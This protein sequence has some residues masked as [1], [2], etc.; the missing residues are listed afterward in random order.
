M[1]QIQAK[2]MISKSARL[3]SI[4]AHT[5]LSLVILSATILAEAQRGESNPPRGAQN[6]ISPVR[7]IEQPPNR[8]EN[9]PR[10]EASSQSQIFRSINGSNNN[11]LDPDIGAAN[12]TLFRLLPS[13]YGDGLSTLAGSNRL[14]AREISNALSAQTESVPNPM[15]ATDFLWQWGQ[16]LDHDIDLTDGADPAEPSPI[17]VPLGDSF[18]DPSG[19][20]DV[21][22]SFNRSIYAAELTGPREQL[23]EITGWIDA[24]NV[25][26]SD[27]ERANALRTLAGDGKLK[28]SAGNL[29]PFN[30]QGFPNAGGDSANLFLAGDVRANEQTGL[31]AMHTLFVREH[32]RLAELVATNNQNWDGEQIYQKTRQLVGAEMQVITYQEFLPTLLG[33]RALGRYQGYRENINASI[34]NSFST[35]AYRFGHSALSPTLL[36][37]DANGQESIHGHLALR[38]AFFSS[39]NITEQGGIEPL[40]RGLASQT[41]QA[42]DL[43]VIDDVRNFLFGAPGAGGFDLAALNIQRG[44]DHGLPSYN[45]FRA[46][47]GLAPHTEFADISSNPETVDQL[48]SVYDSVDAIDL[49]VG[50][51]AEEAISGSHLGALFHAIV[52]DQFEALR[53]GD[54]YWYTLTLNET[55]RQMVESLSLAD[56]IRLNSEIGNEIQDDVFHEASLQQSPLLRAPPR[57]PRP[58]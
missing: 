55:E 30:E 42:I 27:I 11:L 48:S 15:Q 38:D 17:L 6:E 56:I 21:E 44:R 53:D 50:G 16:F 13:D 2:Q 41:C 18:F 47:F 25:Y 58:R 32:N 52:S 10:I 24:S 8:G 33:P 9:I 31:T 20:G 5:T 28:T 34:A 4:T 40:L 45:D 36:R 12:S 3:I 43:K 35:A 1:R 19:S 23:E 29:L 46:A 57:G 37:L 22:I 14:S 26:G 51:L 54:R 39:S 49:W 7:G